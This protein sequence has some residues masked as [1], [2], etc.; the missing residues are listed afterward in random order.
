MHWI[1]LRNKQESKNSN[2]Q[3]LIKEGATGA[4]SLNHR[5]LSR[6]NWAVVKYAHL[7][8]Q[9]VFLTVRSCCE[10]ARDFHWIEDEVKTSLA[11][12]TH[13]VN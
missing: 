12:C 2:S 13:S 7:M 9:F 11:Q 1:L 3:A 5:L 8:L 6:Y 4:I 10:A